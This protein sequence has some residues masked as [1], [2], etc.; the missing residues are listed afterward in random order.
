MV[1][2][3]F[4]DSPFS[5]YREMPLRLREA[6]MIYALH[7]FL[8][9]RGVQIVPHGLMLLSTAMTED[10]IDE[11]LVA[12]RDGMQMIAGNDFE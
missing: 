11:M 2:L 1:A 10:D 3:I 6:K 7:K 8:L 9:N 4:N 12:V 5:N